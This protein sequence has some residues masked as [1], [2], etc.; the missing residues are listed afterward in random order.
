[1]AK[2]RTSSLTF[3]HKYILA[4]VWAM[5]LFYLVIPVWSKGGEGSVLSGISITLMWMWALAWLVMV[6]LRL[7][8]A[9]VNPDHILIKTFNGPQVINYADIEYV[10][11]PML[12]NPQ[13]IS[14]KY[15]DRASGT[16]RNILL[17]PSRS[18][19]LFKFNSFGELEMIQF[20]RQQIRN[21]NPNYSR[22][23]EPARWK[24]FAMVMGSGVVVVLISV[25]LTPGVL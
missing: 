7:R 18:Q 16:S 2:Y 15:E 10:T 20:I 9:E 4:P 17:M 21:F 23:A 6:M 22:H 13:V 24:F 5:G 19:F 25:L 8:R 11:Q 14:I 12:V 3:I 1:M